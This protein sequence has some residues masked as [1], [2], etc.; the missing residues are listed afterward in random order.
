MAKTT[1]AEPK[2]IKERPIECKTV[3]ATEGHI[4]VDAN[5][6]CKEDIYPMLRVV[7]NAK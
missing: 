7:R 6:E 3:K 5:F 1:D 2:T 4:R